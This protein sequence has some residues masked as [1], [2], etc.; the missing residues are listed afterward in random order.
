MSPME[1]PRENRNI[2]MQIAKSN[3]ENPL[4]SYVIRVNCPCFEDIEVEADSIEGAK[5]IAILKF[6][7]PCNGIGEI[8]E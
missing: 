3:I 4:K 8:N 5:E 6:Q 1:T 2:N 7:C